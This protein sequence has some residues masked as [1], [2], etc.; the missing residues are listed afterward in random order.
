MRALLLERD[1]TVSVGDREEPLV[2][3]DEVLV[4]VELCG[5]CG[6]DLHAL[7]T[8]DWI[9]YWPA[10]PGHEVV[11]TVA[12]APIGSGLAAGQRVV[13]D[14]RRPC[15][16]CV[17]CCA[18]RMRH[19]EDLVWMGE[20]SVGGLAQRT[21]VPLTAVHIVP[22]GLTP[23]VAVLAEPLA[24]VL[25]ALDLLPAGT[26]RVVVQG[27]GP[28]GVLSALRLGDLGVDVTVVE[29]D[30]AR[31]ETAARL[32]LTIVAP[33]AAAPGADAVLETAGHPTAL[34]DGLGLL[35]AGGTL[36]AVALGRAPCVVAEADL[37]EHGWSV[38]GSIGFEAA[39]LDRAV[40]V[41][42]AA[43]EKYAG[44]VADVLDL[45]DV[46]RFLEAGGRGALKTVVR[47]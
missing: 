11:G 46:P 3:E 32:G 43:P 44:V 8:G 39:H 36:I 20:S 1:L 21:A 33:G 17:A 13:V 25:S 40:E 23:S 27:G 24:V 35:R 10:S 41:L 45:A 47:P 14:S 4:D 29:A 15:G 38:L 16:R 30:S 42:T 26:D 28:I 34:G 12:S 2:E 31:R 18:G 7:A 22:A 37:V 6:S 5:L 9:T 19:C